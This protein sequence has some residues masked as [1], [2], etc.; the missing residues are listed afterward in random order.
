MN[1]GHSNRATSRDTTY[2]QRIRKKTVIGNID[3]MQEV[4]H[5]HKH[6]HNDRS[7]H[8]HLHAADYVKQCGKRS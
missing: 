3:S 6:G 1:S 4:N 7:I 8:T 5:K 2:L